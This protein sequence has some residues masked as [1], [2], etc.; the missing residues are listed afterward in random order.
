MKFRIAL[1]LILV[2]AL[3][4]L[5]PHPHNFTAIGAMA[6]FGAAYFDKKWMALLIPF[7]ALFLSNLFINN[8][9]Y[10][11][12][13]DGFVW[14]GSLWIYVA[15]ALVIAV[16]RWMLHEH[17]RPINIVT[18]SLTASVVFFIVSNFSSWLEIPAYPKT[19]AGLW[20]CYAAGV[21][22]FGNTVLGDLFFSGVLFGLYQWSTRRLPA[23]TSSAA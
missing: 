9:I 14:L 11:S 8:V 16:G 2:A 21:P 6:L 18:A 5:V 3:S 22:F 10:G 15:F 12:L 13:Y 4:R 19:V 7:A 1:A 23:A 17:V 20:T